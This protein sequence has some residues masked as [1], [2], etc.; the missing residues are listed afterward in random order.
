MTSIAERRAAFRA[1]H[2]SGCFVLPNPWDG[3]SAIRLAKLG[4]QALAS[5]SAGAAWA[6]GRADGEMT[7]EEV[8]EHLRFLVGITDLPVNA[9]F[10]AGFADTPE[11]V[12]A[13]VARCVDTGVAGLSIEDRLGSDLYPLDE[14][15]KRVRAARE[16]IDRSGQEVLLV[17]RCE[18]FGLG[19]PDLD[20][21]VARL[22]AYGQ[23][24][25]DCLYAPGIR[26]LAA[27][28]RLVRALDKPV[29]A[30]LPGAGLTVA[31]LAGVG[32][33][34]VSVGGALARATWTA[35]EGFAGML[36]AQGRLPG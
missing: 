1:L 13:N 2:Q 8:L 15:V 4:F 36:R 9:D 34:R 11:G 35:F 22:S 24:G 20:A 32:V 18:G 3:G 29:N 31:D 14:A 25:A 27:I 7:V 23:A 21:T 6:L 16:A 12:A 19:Q 26:D 30:N 17:G 33:R 28:A 5:T 10:G